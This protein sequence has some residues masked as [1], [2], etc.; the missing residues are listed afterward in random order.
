MGC[1]GSKGKGGKVE[2]KTTELPA[3]DEFF[4]DAQTIIN[5]LYDLKDP[6]DKAREDLIESTGFDKILCGNSQHATV[7]LVFA[8]YAT[9]ST[10]DD[11][12][13]AVDIKLEEPFLTFDESKVTG[14]IIQDTKH[15]LLYVEALTKAKDQ[16]I[17]LIDKIKEVV[18]KTP[19]MPGKAKDEISN[20]QGLGLRQK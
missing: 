4:N 8:I 5:Q 2:M 16:I 1:G 20:A 10:V 3:I 6:I 17:P 19:D 13:N 12:L 14:P 7:G 18:K 9:S 15:F 11:A